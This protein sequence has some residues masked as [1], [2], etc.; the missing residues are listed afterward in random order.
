ME[1]SPSTEEL[2]ASSGSIW[3]SQAPNLYLAMQLLNTYMR[4]WENKFPKEWFLLAINSSIKGYIW[5]L[6]LA[7]M[8]E[9]LMNSRLCLYLDVFFVIH[10]SAVATPCVL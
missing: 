2:A 9:S 1:G 8:I 3:M 7:L 4:T 5:T 6:L 10:P